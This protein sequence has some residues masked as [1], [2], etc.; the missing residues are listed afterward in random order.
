MMMMMMMMIHFDGEEII[1]QY[2]T[3]NTISVLYPLLTLQT[4]CNFTNFVN[5][6][7]SEMLKLHMMMIKLKNYHTHH[8]KYDICCCY[9]IYQV[10]IYIMGHL[11]W[12]SVIGIQ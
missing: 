8:R 7:S 3:L 4:S 9:G 10:Q 12:A 1:Y 6:K 5:M 11:F 2:Y